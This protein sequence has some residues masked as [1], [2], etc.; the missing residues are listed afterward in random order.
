[1]G[2][3]K[4][5]IN[6]VQAAL[7]EDIGPGDLTSR[8]CLEPNPAKAEIV[9][10]QD[11]FL[12]GLKPALLVFHIVDSA[13]VVKPCFKDGDSFKAGDR[14]IEIDGFNLTLMASERVVLNF[15]AHLSGIATL[16]NKFVQ[17]I[18][19]TNC[20]ILDTRKTTPGWRMLEK[21][22]VVHG[23]GDNHRY[24]LYD[25]ILVKDNH[26]ASAGSISKALNQIQEYLHSDEYT[27]QFKINPDQ[28]KIEVEIS[29]EEQLIEAL[30]CK[31]DRLMLDNQS[32]D[33]LGILVAKARMINS[34]IE[35]EASGN[36]SLENVADIA[37]TGVDLISIG[38]LTHS[39]PVVDLSM[40]IVE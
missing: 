17:K 12:S 30:K 3:D 13:N 39:A 21:E 24:G 23:G 28:V 32:R 2:I 11:G 20:K 27:D 16:T 40:K 19:G 1:M 25:M 35:L 37:A 34:K 38:A 6:L 14:I 4:S 10:K 18:K 26:I 36:V 31:V 9:A 15:L 22:A 29:T 5:I 33:S 8:A 7:S